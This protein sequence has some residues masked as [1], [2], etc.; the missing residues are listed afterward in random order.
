MIDTDVLLYLIIESIETMISNSK[1][2]ENNNG[3]SSHRNQHQGQ[4]QRIKH[5]QETK[6]L[7]LS[8]SHRARMIAFEMAAN[9]RKNRGRKKQ[10]ERDE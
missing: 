2:W 8:Q 6:A 10:K 9:R 4:H 5:I 7:G 3:N 1:K